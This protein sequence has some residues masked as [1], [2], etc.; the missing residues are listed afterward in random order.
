MANFIS[1]EDIQ[2]RLIQ[3]LIDDLK[4]DEHLFCQYKEELERK[5]ESEVISFI[6]LEKALNKLNT[7]LDRF[8]AT[9]KAE[10]IRQAKNALT[11]NRKNM[12]ILAANK[13]IHTLLKD[14]YKSIIK[15]DS[16]KNQSIKVQY[17]DFRQPDNNEFVAAEEVWINQVDRRRTDILI[18]VNGL[19][20]VFFE[21]KNSDIPVKNAYTN[22]LNTYR[23]KIPTLFHYNSFLILSNGL[24]TKIGSIT[25]SWEHFSEWKRIE[26]ETETYD[27]KE[28]GISLERVT[29]GMCDK[30]RL[31]DII[32]NF[33]FYISDKAKIVAKNHQYLGVNNAV[34]SFENRLNQDGK[35]G[36]FWH[37][38]GS[39]KSFSMIF[40]TMK[41]FRKYAGTYTF[42]IVTDRESLD[43][44]I[45][46]NFLNA[47]VVKAK[48]KAQ[49]EDRNDLK[50]KLGEDNKRYIF[51]LIQKFGT[52]K[53][54]DFPLLTNRN[55]IIVLVDEA[56]RTQYNGFA[57]N[58][59]TAM[60]NANYLAFTGTPLLDAN[61]T[62]K[63]WFGDYVSEY[64]FAQSI[65]D[66]ATVPLFYED[67][68]PEVQQNNN[69]LNND[70]AKIMERDNLTEEQEEQLKQKYAT[71]LEIIKRD[72]RL[73]VIAKDIV[74]H[75]PNRAFK[76]KGMVISVD[77]YTTVKMYDK[78]KRHWKEK[79]RSLHKE[80]NAET[81]PEKAEALT[82]LQAYMKETEMY[83]IISKD[84]NEEDR[85]SKQ[86]LLIKSHRDAMEKKYGSNKLSLEE[87]FKID[88]DLFRLVF[89][90]SKWLTGFD[91]P[92]VSTLYIDKP[93][94]NHTLMQTIARANRV[95]PNK[96]C[97]ILIDYFGVFANLEK[98][99]EKYGK[100]HNNKLKD[101]DKPVQKK[102]ALKAFLVKAIDAG[103]E[104]LT[105]NECDFK[106]ILDSKDAF[107]LIKLFGI[108]A[109]NLSKTE[110]LRKEYNVYENAIQNLYN[111]TQPDDE[112][113]KMY[114]RTKEAFEYLRKI[115]NREIKGGDFDSA[116]EETR[117]LLDES[118]TSDGYE[119]SVVREPRAIYTIKKSDEL[120]LRTINMNKVEARF[121]KTAYKYLAIVDFKAFLEKQ[122][123]AMSKRV[124]S[125]KRMDFAKRL[126]EI[127][128]NYNSKT[129]DVN[130]FFEELKQYAEALKEED[131]RHIKEGLTEKELQIFDLLVTDDKLTEKQKKTIKLAAKELLKKLKAEKN[132]IMY[133]DW[134][135]NQRQQIAVERYIMKQLF[136]YLIEAYDN[137][138]DM[139]KQRS[140][141]LYQFM[142]QDAVDGGQAFA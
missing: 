96:T 118:I 132:K 91:S 55:D 90:C 139:F 9:F 65:E 115:I 95:Y 51:T 74:A 75:F 12:S 78:V 141:N 67:R 86:N 100:K 1:E 105:N 98:A 37:T 140:E 27:N 114:K 46:L 52:A 107:S 125:P 35:L 54:E 129:I 59:R 133:A 10:A 53:G 66:G 28:E 112:V 17:L 142:Y 29:K 3:L 104:F 119:G 97:G 130:Q 79:I 85:F 69:A 76:G 6:R 87:R 14:G 77:K 108:Y 68:V 7:H 122:I 113:S 58:M 117:N 83:V 99:L 110:S 23:R 93:M 109:N 121:K 71:E 50:K 92:T 22:N 80:I 34:T 42:V 127:I 15:D 62:T 72:G 106:L 39:G 36:V 16:G 60:P 137:D 131:L 19:P 73:E 124:K 63:K 30:A 136:P 18:Y 56:H 57:Q 128:D 26:D 40:F 20:L 38:Q 89:V 134:H 45:Y 5:N 102:E 2:K 48:D 111:A 4:Y 31:L 47:E 43:D 81:S 64:N 70:L 135:K 116:V 49:A 123:K 138:V 88:D 32:E 94:Q 13:E 11:E 61:E 126:Q 33:I 44:Q 101:G 21:L 82:A 103:I 120:D 25:A 84:G 8:G 24:H 41:V